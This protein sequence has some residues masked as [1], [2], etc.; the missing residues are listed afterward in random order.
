[1]TDSTIWIVFIVLVF[2]F[3]FGAAVLSDGEALGRW[4]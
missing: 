4:K 1:M 2:V 3:I